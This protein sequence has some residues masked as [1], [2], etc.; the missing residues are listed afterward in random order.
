MPWSPHT[1]AESTS[2]PPPAREPPS[3][4][5]YRC[6]PI[7]VTEAQHPRPHDPAS[8]AP[9]DSASLPGIESPRAF[10]LLDER[11]PGAEAVAAEAHVAVVAEGRPGA[12]R[13]CP[14]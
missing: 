14:G 8:E 11:F 1:T 9:E 5:C 3:A 12:C 6:T 13:C 2:A 7:R 4:S 10:D